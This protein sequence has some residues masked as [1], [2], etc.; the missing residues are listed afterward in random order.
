LHYLSMK[1]VYPPDLINVVL[2]KDFRNTHYGEG[3]PDELLREMACLDFCAELELE[4]YTGSR[5]DKSTFGHILQCHVAR[6]NRGVASDFSKVSMHESN[7]KK[8]FTD[9]ESLVDDEECHGIF[10]ILPQHYCKKVV[11]CTGRQG[12]FVKIPAWYITI[13]EHQ[14][15]WIRPKE[16]KEPAF[17][18]LYLC[19][20]G[21]SIR[22]DDNMTLSGLGKMVVRQLRKM[23]YIVHLIY[24]PIA[25]KNL[26][27]RIFHSLG[28]PKDRPRNSITRSR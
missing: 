28:N 22:K 3:V 19:N 4:G 7:L 14:I 15:K 10:N 27:Q 5:L 23:G 11:F 13:P 1:E 21:D 18:V 8:I 9:V 2:S 12:E 17:H 25:N 6:V 20:R 16:K 26:V 24:P